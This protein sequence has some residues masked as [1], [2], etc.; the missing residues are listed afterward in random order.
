MGRIIL[1]LVVTLIGLQSFGQDSGLRMRGVTVVAPPK[2][3]ESKEFTDLKEINTEWVALVPYGFSSIG[4]TS[5]RYNLDRQWWGEKEEGIRAC[6]EMA[7]AKGLKVMLKPQVYIH[8]AWVGDVS[9]DTE[10]EWLE[11][12][13]QYSSFIKFYAKIAAEMDVD[14]LCIATEY[15]K[16]V[17][18][19]PDYWKNLI[20]EIR[21]FYK[22]KLIYSSNWDSY[23]KLPIWQ[24]LDYIGISA[25]FPLTD[26]K[27]PTINNLRKKWKPIKKKLKKF[28]KKYDKPIV[29]TEYGYL[30]VDKCAWRTWELEKNIKSKTINQEAQ[31]IA[32][33]AL[34]S[35]LWKEDW[36]G[37][38]FIWKWFPS[39]MGHEG[40]P[41]RDY[42]PQGKKASKIIKEW[43][44]KD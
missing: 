39:G 6:I 17:L 26:Q 2:S 40:Y 22:G 14:M 28:S 44:G 21:S 38:G 29:F 36:W 13:S 15:K 42:T 7:K 23:D 3:F 16:A 43:Y 8:G 41:E 32:F 33:Q 34:Y 25:Y 24:D 35:S 27:T 18:D 19:R 5:V 37:G 30:T 12:E 20:K 4:E 11:W 1:L 10:S 31:A 9:F